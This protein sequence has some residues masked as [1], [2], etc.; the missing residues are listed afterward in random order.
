MID[1]GN[2]DRPTQEKLCLLQRFLQAFTIARTEAEDTPKL[3]PDISESSLAA[4]KSSKAVAS[5]TGAEE[6]PSKHSP[7]TPSP[8]LPGRQTTP[9][10]VKQV[11]TSVPYDS[12]CREP[13]ASF[14]NDTITAPY[15]STG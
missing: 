2:L 12:Y 8:S 3:T 11:T 6:T 13:T 1:G 5:A 15:S 9:I 14:T 10:T 4:E 7:S